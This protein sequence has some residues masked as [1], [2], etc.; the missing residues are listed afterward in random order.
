MATKP[1]PKRRASEHLGSRH[2][3]NEHQGIHSI[4]PLRWV[5]QI[6]LGFDF[7]RVSG[8]SEDYLSQ[9]GREPSL[10]SESIFQLVPSVQGME[11]R[12]K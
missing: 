11:K 7:G 10:R 5:T 3:K 2:V 4:A 6:Q 1:M 8:D 12:K 9:T